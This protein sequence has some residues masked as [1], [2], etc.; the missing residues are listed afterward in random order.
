MATTAR[1]ADKRCLRGIATA[2]WICGVGKKTST[3]GRVQWL[4][5]APSRD[6]SPARVPRSAHASH[7]HDPAQLTHSVASTPKTRC[8]HSISILH[9]SQ[10]PNKPL[11]SSS[12]TSPHAPPQHRTFPRTRT[13]ISHHIV[14]LPHEHGPST[15]LH[16]RL[17]TQITTPCLTAHT[18]A[19][20][21]G[22]TYTHTH[23]HEPSWPPLRPLAPRRAGV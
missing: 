19:L 23:T 15:L 4:H 9:N 20:A 2:P 11:R 18:P 10:N 7:A 22:H 6:A 17:S 12:N 1:V 13:R 16:K 21:H 14:H 3:G 5:S 8:P